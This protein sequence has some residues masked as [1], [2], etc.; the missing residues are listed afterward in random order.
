MLK[1]ARLSQQVDH[2]VHHIADA[3]ESLS[4]MVVRLQEQCLALRKAQ[5][6]SRAELVQAFATL[7]GQS[8]E[9]LTSI[10]VQ[11]VA[12]WRLLAYDVNRQTAVMTM[13]TNSTADSL[14]QPCINKDPI[15]TLMRGDAAISDDEARRMYKDIIESE[16]EIVCQASDEHGFDSQTAIWDRLSAYIEDKRELAM[17]ALADRSCIIMRSG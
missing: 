14:A 11:A 12:A 5:R 16:T 10:G 8:T 9:A 1:Q 6:E 4:E 15:F 13:T 2:D 17:G 3:T 7:K